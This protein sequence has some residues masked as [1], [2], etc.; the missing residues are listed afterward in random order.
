MNNLVGKRI[1]IVRTLG[2]I[3]DF[4]TYNCQEIGLSKVLAKTGMNVSLIFAGR[5]CEQKIISVSEQIK[6]NIYYI[7]FIG[8]KPLLSKFI[9]I[10]KVLSKLNPDIIQIH[11]FNSLMSYFV[12]KWALRNNVKTVLI[13]GP[14]D[15]RHKGFISQY[16]EKITNKLTGIYVLR[17]VHGTGCKTE[18][19]LKYLN[20]YYNRSM[21]LTRIGLDRSRFE[22]IKNENWKKKLGLENKKILL[23]VGILEKRRNVDLLIKLLPKLPHDFVLLIVGKGE[24]ETKLQHLAMHLNVANR[25][26]FLGSLQQ[27]NL[28]SLY[29]CCDL[30]LLPSSYEIY[31]MVLLEAMYF[32]LPVISSITGGSQTIIKNNETGISI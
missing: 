26:M 2:N 19:A 29:S 12:L 24:K 23:Y 11:E 27:E 5:I 18:M 14:Y 16:I 25:C 8:L 7:P 30:F 21:Y 13:Q 10:D 28:P 4:N 3:V 17:K 32:S 6:I 15:Y 20:H 22:Q 31:G 9:G 1:V